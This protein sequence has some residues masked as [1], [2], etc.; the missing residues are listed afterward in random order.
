[1]DMSR[2]QNTTQNGTDDDHIHN[3]NDCDPF[4]RDP[5]G[6][7]AIIVVVVAQLVVLSKL[8]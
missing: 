3:Q 4:F 7:F 1:M 5:P 2:A 6:P 8:V